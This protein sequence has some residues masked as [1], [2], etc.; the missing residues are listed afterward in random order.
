MIV[1][2]GM[3]WNGKNFEKKD[4]YIQD[5]KF[6]SKSEFKGSGPVVDATG[7]FVMPGF[8]DSHAHV[9]GTGVKLLTHNLDKKSIDDL[10]DSDDSFIIARGW[11]ILPDNQSLQFLNRLQKPVALI[12]KC[13][14]VAWVNNYLKNQ[15]LL[16]DNLI[17]E[18]EIEKI[19]KYLGDDFY[20][21]AF[22][23]GIEEFVKYGV[24]QVHSDDF[25]GISFKKLKE[26]LNNSKIRIFEKL[27]TVRPWDYEFGTFNLSRIGGIKLFADGSLGGKTAYMFEPYVGTDHNGIFTIPDNIKEIILF[28][29]K[30]KLQLNIHTIGD[31]ALHEVLRIF[32]ENQANTFEIRHRLIHLQ[33][34]KK[35]DF[36]KLKDYYLSVQPHFYFEDIEII[37]FARYEMAYPFLEMHKAKY[38]MAFSTD[39]PVSPADPKYVIESALK[40]GF[41]KQ[42]AINLYT[43]SGSRMAD[44]KA[45]KIKEGYLADFCLFDSNP[46][47][48]EPLAVYINGNEALNTHGGV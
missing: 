11:E 43:E 27:Y 37:K 14:H 3:V 47:E 38:D 36:P 12:R 25:H 44:I 21:I 13:G 41:S 20:E 40:M 35:E 26:L 2:N 6:V 7:L 34:V 5:G 42:E 32:E 22:Q 28:A 24:T 15:A 4:L 29:Q 1:K 46:L 17:Y 16:S 31:K 8:V 48:S 10:A 39:S 33:F 9:I 45:G 30:N 23:K 19:W 18:A